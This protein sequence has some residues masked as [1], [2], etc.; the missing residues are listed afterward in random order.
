MFASARIVRCIRF[1]LH[2]YLSSVH[3]TSCDKKK[4]LAP[5]QHYRSYHVNDHRAPS[6]RWRRRYRRDVG[7]PASLPG[8]GST[9]HVLRRRRR[10]DVCSLWFDY[11]FTAAADRRPVCLLPR[12]GPSPWACVSARVVRSPCLPPSLRS[13]VRMS[14]CLCVRRR[15]SERVSFRASSPPAGATSVLTDRRAAGYSRRRSV[16]R[17]GRVADG[18]ARPAGTRPSSRSVSSTDRTRRRAEPSRP[19]L[20]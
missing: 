6:V 20:N 19:G 2:C 5:A 3:E 16:G 8:T 4:L 15:A 10:L 12:P 17:G 13:S 18:R 9:F 7:L 11:R 1:Q 14:L